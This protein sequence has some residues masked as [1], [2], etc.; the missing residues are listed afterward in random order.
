[1]FNVF[2][3]R[4]NAIY[5]IYPPFS[6]TTRR[7]RGRTWLQVARTVSPSI[8]SHDLINF[9]LRTSTLEC[10]WE[11]AFCFKIDHIP[12]SI[13]LRS[14]EDGDQ[15][16][17]HQKDLKSRKEKSMVK[18]SVPPVIKSYLVS[19][20]L[21]AKRVNILS[22]LCFIWHT[23]IKHYFTLYHILIFLIVF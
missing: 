22:K 15:S 3:V 16:F 9:C 21:S 5:T 17:F 2:Y 13:W 12:K 23:I 19:S 20:V 14:G 11:Q 1:M 7:R 10:D 18:L 4:W 8:S 6:R